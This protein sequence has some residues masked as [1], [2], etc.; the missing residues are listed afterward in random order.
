MAGQTEY[1]LGIAWKALSSHDDGAEWKLIPIRQ[2]ASFTAQAARRFPDNLEALAIGF[3]GKGIGSNRKLPEGGGFEVLRTTIENHGF[4]SSAIVLVR[5]ASGPLEIF[6]AM[7]SDIL[8]LLDR[9]R[10][11]SPPVLVNRF[12][13]RVVAWQLF[14]QPPREGPLGPEAQ[15]GLFGELCFMN[16]LLDSGMSGLLAVDAWDGPMRGAQDYRIGSGAVEVKS[17]TAAEGFNAKIQS[18]EQ[19]DDM[20]CHPLFLVALR[21]TDVPEGQTLPE[22]VTIIRQR[23]AIEEGRSAFEGK[24]GAVGYHDDHAAAY[25]RRLA[26]AEERIFRV[27]V[28]FP[29]LIRGNIAAAVQKARYEIELDGV[30]VGLT[31]SGA[32]FHEL[33]LE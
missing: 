28:G 21:F 16:R 26:L 2:P 33:G 11:A 13:D 5:N 25:G 9:N 18:L 23:L 6:H 4:D 17:S 3:P 10:L 27:G 15:T 22:L 32:L 30:D 14:M 1:E 12:L 7:A 19:L 31:D 8:A 24:L 20:E 29:R